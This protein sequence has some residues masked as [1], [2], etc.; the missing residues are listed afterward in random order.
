MRTRYEKDLFR[1][2]VATGKASTRAEAEEIIEGLLATIRSLR[3]SSHQSPATEKTIF[4]LQAA[5]A[6]I[7]ETMPR[8]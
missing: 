2:G 3:E 7:R 5:I 8:A 6:G 4:S 1:L